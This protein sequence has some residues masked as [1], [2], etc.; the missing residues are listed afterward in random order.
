MDAFPLIVL[1]GVGIVVLALVLVARFYP[2]SGADLLDWQPSR[3]YEVELELEEQDVQQM[4]DAQNK[5]RRKRGA[6]DISESDVRDSVV[7][8]HPVD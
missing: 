4:I 8:D 7:R 3:S 6:P 2:G 5:L 1:G